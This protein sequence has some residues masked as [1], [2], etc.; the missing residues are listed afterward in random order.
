VVCFN[1]V[2]LRPVSVSRT[3]TTI[4]ITDYSAL[5]LKPLA[6]FGRGAKCEVSRTFSNMTKAQRQKTP[7][8]LYMS[9]LKQIL[10]NT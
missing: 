7:E 4:I 1:C 9:V 10:S 6:K 8:A 3:T 5:K 2:S